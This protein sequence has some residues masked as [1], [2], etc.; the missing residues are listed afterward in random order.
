MP[1]KNL[2]EGAK[3]I[4]VAAEAKAREGTCKDEKDKEKCINSIAWSAVKNK[5]KQDE[6]GNWIPK[7]EVSRFSMAITRTSYD[8]AT[9][10]RRWKA[11]ASDTASDLYED[12]MTVELYE[13]FMQRMESKESPPSLSRFGW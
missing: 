8:K 5:F 3:K 4:F 10:T 13:D 7:A 1:P 11:V 9:D 6:D 12:N 2:P